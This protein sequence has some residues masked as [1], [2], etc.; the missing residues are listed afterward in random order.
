MRRAGTA[1]ST[2]L[3]DDPETVATTVGRARPGFEVRLK[4]ARRILKLPSART[5]DHREPNV[6]GRCSTDAAAMPAPV[7]GPIVACDGAG[8]ASACCMR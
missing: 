2:G 3:E 5:L 1:T 7:A 6:R 4:A 8:G